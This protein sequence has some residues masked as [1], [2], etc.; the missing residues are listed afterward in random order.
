MLIKSELQY[1]S[2]LNTNKC[3]NDLVKVNVSLERALP[4][5]YVIY[6]LLPKILRSKDITLPMHAT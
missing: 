1:I 2:L 6:L 4:I 5:L 3:N